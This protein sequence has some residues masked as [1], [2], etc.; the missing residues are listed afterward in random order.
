MTNEI[1]VN[2]ISRNFESIKKVDS[3]GVEYWEARELMPLLGY[4]R[5]ENFQKVINKA[6]DA[7]TNSQQNEKNHF[8]D[9][10]KMV[11]IG[12]GS[13]RN[14]RDFNLSRYTCAN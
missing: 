7:C 2:G 11:S 3:D 1:S 9:V 10:T 4:D 13:Q 5:W 12:S 8:L 6:I 14:V